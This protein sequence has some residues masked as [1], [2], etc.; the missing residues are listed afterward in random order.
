MKITFAISPNNTNVVASPEVKALI[1]KTCS[2]KSKLISDNNKFTKFNKNPIINYYKNDTFPTGLLKHVVEEL[3]NTHNINLQDI[4]FDKS[5]LSKHVFSKLDLP[6]WLYPHQIQIINKC[7]EFKRGTIQSPTGSGKTIAI[8]YLIKNYLKSLNESKN[9]ETIEIL[10]IVPS[11]QL[12][13]AMHKTLEDVLDEEVGQLYNLQKTTKRVTVGLIN[14]VAIY[15]SSKKTLFKSINMVV[16]DEAHKAMSSSYKK[17][18]NA[19]SNATYKLG[20]SGTIKECIDVFRLE[21]LIGPLVLTIQEE[22]LLN[23]TLI[24][25][26]IL[27]LCCEHDS[28]LTVDGYQDAYTKHIVNNT[29]RNKYVVDIASFWLDNNEGGCLILVE[30]IE[31]GEILKK[32]FL[33]NNRDVPF[34]HGETDQKIREQVLQNLINEKQKICIASRIFNEGTDIPCLGL[35]IVTNAGKS[36]IRITQQIGRALRK[37]KN[38]TSTKKNAIIVDFKDSSI[39][40]SSAYQER[41]KQIELRFPGCINEFQ[42]YYALIKY[43][44]S[45]K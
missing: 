5:L 18:L 12:L 33:L 2:F 43:L 42:K 10:V 39:F 26:T 29:I 15:A 44:E 14:T 7:I 3:V 28:T 37:F 11:Q 20:L 6:D 21:A 31:H 41:S 35:V 16:V 25:P 36:A 22:D 45:L 8:S 1:K 32:L 9:S 4:I 27:A 17:A 40:F 34:L 23:K 30:K 13:L 24:K 19:C 38:E